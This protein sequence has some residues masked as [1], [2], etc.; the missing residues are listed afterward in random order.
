[1]FP[2]VG[3]NTTTE[4]I[5]RHKSGDRCKRG[6]KTSNINSRSKNSKEA[7]AVD[8]WAGAVENDLEGVGRREAAK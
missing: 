5:K 6:H 7:T 3:E 1:M 8:Y 4:S 2:L